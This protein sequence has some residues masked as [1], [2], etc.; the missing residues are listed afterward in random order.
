ESLHAPPRSDGLADFIWSAAFNEVFSHNL[1]QD[2]TSAKCPSKSPK[3][4]VADIRARLP[5]RPFRSR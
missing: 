5:N 1:G 3:G 2:R 4:F